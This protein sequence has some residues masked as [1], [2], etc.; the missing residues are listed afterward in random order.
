MVSL[1]IKQLNYISKMTYRSSCLIILLVNPPVFERNITH[2]VL[3]RGFSAHCRPLPALPSALCRG[4]VQEV[5]SFIS[6]THGVFTRIWRL[7][8]QMEEIWG[9]N[10]EKIWHRYHHEPH[11]PGDILANPTHTSESTSLQL[12]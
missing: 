10:Q 9:L 6:K 1:V 12:G 3:L 2:M 4:V 11:P 7:Y 5:G 8:Q